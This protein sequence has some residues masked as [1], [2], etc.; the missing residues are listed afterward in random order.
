MNKNH[1]QTARI[2]LGAKHNQ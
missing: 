1:H 2:S